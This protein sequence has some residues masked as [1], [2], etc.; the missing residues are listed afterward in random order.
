MLLRLHR[1][2]STP[3]AQLGILLVP[4]LRPIATL[5]LPWKDNERNVSC[6]PCGTYELSLH[7]SSRFGRCFAVNGVQNRDG[8]LIHPGNTKKDTEG[9]ILVGYKFGYILGEE[10]VL[11]SKEAMNQLFGELKLV[12]EEL[13]LQIL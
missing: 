7:V 11:N 1:L 13:I 2:P 9:C 12:T 4:N 6:V 3:N 10:A 8:I 5:E